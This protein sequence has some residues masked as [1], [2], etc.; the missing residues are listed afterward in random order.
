MGIVEFL[1]DCLDEDGQ[2]AR[3]ADVD[4]TATSPDLPRGT[5]LVYGLERVGY[6]L[7]YQMFASAWE[8]SRVLREIA[9]KRR[10]L[11]RHRD[12]DFPFNPDDGPGDYAWTGRC[13]YCHE[14]WPCPELRDLAAG[15][16]D[17]PGYKPGW[18]PEPTNTA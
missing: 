10:I 17:R 11:E 1:T 7:N 8:P 4:W 13:D 15:Y 6:G 18:A 9:V 2:L 16:A 14:A 12:C 3:D 5:H